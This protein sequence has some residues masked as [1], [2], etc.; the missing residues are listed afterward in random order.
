MTSS[1]R[2]IDRWFPVAAVDAACGTPAGSGRVEKAIFSWF[3]S[4]PIA[5]ARGATIT[6]LLMYDNAYKSIIDNAIRLD[7]RDA[8]FNIADAVHKTYG[9]RPPIVLD[10]FSGRG[11]IPLEAARAGAISL[12]TDLSPVATLAGRLL[13]DYPARDWNSEA[14]LPFAS[15]KGARLDFATDGQ[16]KLVADVEVFLEE[17]GQRVARRVEKY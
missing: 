17:V 14:P 9:G 1:E 11:I 3:A 16:K 10:M 5:Q 2:M 15:G 8:V 6:S 4:R 12:G 7:D 13:A